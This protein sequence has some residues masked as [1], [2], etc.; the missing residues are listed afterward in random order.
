LKIFENIEKNTSINL[1]Y[2]KLFFA[3]TYQDKET[4]VKEML[5]DN[6]SVVNIGVYIH[7]PQILID[8]SKGELSLR[9]ALGHRLELNKYSY[10]EDTINQDIEIQLLNKKDILDI[11]KIYQDRN[12]STLQKMDL[13]F[14]DYQYLLMQGN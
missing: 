3:Q 11:N 8:I 6:E 9:P 2:R 12:Y 7:Y 4:L 1:G 13:L 14:L 5:E 10:K